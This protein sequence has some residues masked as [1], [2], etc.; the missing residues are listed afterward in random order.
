MASNPLLEKKKPNPALR[1][2]I[3]VG[4]LLLVALV[5]YLEFAPK[6]K[7]EEIPLTAE[8][9]GYIRNLALEDVGMKA[10]LDYFG[11]KVV[12]IQGQIGNTGDRP[13][14]IVEVTCVFRDYA[15]QVVLRQRSP[16]VSA[17]M[18]GLKP[19]E[20][21]SFRLPFDEI[22]ANWNQQMPNLV[23]AGITFE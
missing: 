4:A 11:Q 10:K 19:G 12:E 22:P 9:K 23:I 21:K 17:K 14:K 2:L 20:K 7:V 13:L 3:A 6:P 5:G 18:G 1:P 8:A 16:I 15:N